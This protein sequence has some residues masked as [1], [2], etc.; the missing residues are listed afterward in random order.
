MVDINTDL[1]SETPSH[2]T[3]DNGGPLTGE[4]DL[5]ELTQIDQRQSLSREAGEIHTRMVTTLLFRPQR[6]NLFIESELTQEPEE[7]SKTFWT[8]A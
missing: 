7:T 6:V 4:P 5:S 8:S 1:G 3:T 2:G